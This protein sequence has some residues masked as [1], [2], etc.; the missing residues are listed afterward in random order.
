MKN[1][2][3]NWIVKVKKKPRREPG[4]FHNHTQLSDDDGDD[5]DDGG[6]DGGD[7]RQEQR[8]ELLG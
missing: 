5:G 7:A 6:G 3:R 4:Q 2:E 1:F 8:L